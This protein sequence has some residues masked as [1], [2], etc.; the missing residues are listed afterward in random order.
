MFSTR[1]LRA[2]SLAF[3]LVLAAANGTLLAGDEPEAKEPHPAV[4]GFTRNIYNLQKEGVKDLSV[5][6]DT[7]I[8][9]GSGIFKHIKVMVHFKTP[10]RHA[11]DIQGMPEETRQVYLKLFKPIATLTRYLFGLGSILVEVLDDAEILVVEEKGLFKIEASPRSEK[12]AAEFK[13][14]VL[15]VD[16][17]Y[18]PVKIY[19]ESPDL[20]NIS[21]RLETTVKE[22]K[23]LVSALRVKG[24]KGIDGEIRM[25]IKYRKTGKY[26]LPSTVTMR[27]VKEGQEPEK[28]GGAQDFHFKDY[29]IN[30]GLPDSV[31]GKEDEPKEGEKKEEDY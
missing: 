21:V 25:K 23:N 19:Q 11:L 31:F 22:E 28:E 13:K 30:K 4:E 10:D 1:I 7:P 27:I 5:E 12:L 15:W 8:F 20:G 24:V 17:S 9:R 29:K 6:L 18:K 26:W 14:I 16:A 2:S 3:V